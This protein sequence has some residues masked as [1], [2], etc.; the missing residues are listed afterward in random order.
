MSEIMVDLSKCLGCHTCELACA[1][2]HAE[3]GSLLAI[4]LAGELP[5]NRIRVEQGKTGPVPLQ[6]RHC[7]DARCLTA[8][9][10]GSLYREGELVLQDPAKCVGCWMC[11]MVCPFGSIQQDHAGSKAVKCDRCF[12]REGGPA[13]VEACPTKALT[14]TAVDLFS[15]EK[16]RRYLVEFVS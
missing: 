11:V 7:S 3:N 1:T 13:C 12:D 2:A 5:V 9:M 15:Q 6:C 14:L 16:R 10:T 8:C 4:V